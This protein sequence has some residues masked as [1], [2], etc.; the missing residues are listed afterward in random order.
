MICERLDFLGPNFVV[1]PIIDDYD[2]DR[3][4]D[5]NNNK[6]S[7]KKHHWNLQD[8]KDALYAIVIH[9]EKN[10]AHNF[11][12][13]KYALVMS[14]GDRDLAEILLHEEYDKITMK[15]HMHQIGSALN[16]LHTRCKTYIEIFCFL[17]D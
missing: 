5:C 16:Q 15:D 7:S 11:S 2:T 3:I 1:F 6:K 9:E 10:C 13:Y 17:N 4:N 14:R 8:S 12:L